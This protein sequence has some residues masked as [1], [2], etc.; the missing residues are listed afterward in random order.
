VV[1]GDAGA[2]SLVASA[3]TVLVAVAAPSLGY[4]LAVGAPELGCEM[5]QII[6]DRLL[7]LILT[8]F[9]LQKK[10]KKKQERR[11]VGFGT[12]DHLLL[13]RSNIGPLIPCWEIN[14]FEIC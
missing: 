9:G 12:P 6:I 11:E 10:K 4:A 13:E 7:S 8:H 2:V 3:V 5:I 14:K 1:S